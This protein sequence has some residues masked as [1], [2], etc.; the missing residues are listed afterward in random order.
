MRGLDPR[1]HP[2]LN[3]IVCD[4]RHRRRA[5]RFDRCTDA[6]ERGIA[7][8]ESRTKSKKACAGAE[9]RRR[10]PRHLRRH[11]CG[12]RR[13]VDG[14]AHER[15]GAQAHDRDRRGLV[16]LALA[17]GAVEE[18]RKLRPHP[19]RRRDAGRLR[20]GCGLDQG[21]AARRG[22]LPHRAAV[23]LLPRGAAASRPARS[24][25]NS[26]TPSKAFDPHAVYDKK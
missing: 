12:Q 22:R 13:A 9:V 4:C 16:L 6:L 1:I 23:V 21:R 20:S 8:A 2:A 7:V 17:Q 25:W 11:R 18:G 26:A 24:R 3:G 14:R 15:R 5:R 10:W 19:A